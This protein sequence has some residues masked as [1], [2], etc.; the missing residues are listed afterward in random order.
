MSLHVK[1][2]SRTM[3]QLRADV[4]MDLL[5]GVVPTGCEESSTGTTGSVEI[6]CNLATLTEL[7]DHL[8]ELSGYGPVIAGIVRQVA[9]R[10]VDSDWR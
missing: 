6:V 7:A 8:G 10:Q 4:Y 5:Q 2:E 3:D 1:G 9:R